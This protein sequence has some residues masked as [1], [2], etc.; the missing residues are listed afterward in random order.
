MSSNGFHSSPSHIHNLRSLF[1]VF[2][3]DLAIDLGT[4][5]TLVYARGKGIV[6]NEPSIVAMNKV[7]GEV[8][9]VGREAKEMLGRTPGNIVAIRPMKD[10]VIADFE[11]TEAML[12]YF[13]QKAHH[14]RT[15]VRPRVIVCVPS[16]ITEV[17]KRA[18]RDSALAASA[19]EVYLVGEPMAAA[20]GGG[21]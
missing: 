15:L 10:G 4:A 18:V 20:I 11:V 13:I 14:R 2:S 19:R 16:G 21:P 9:A 3:S 12:R 1:S 6:V 5:N 7:T 8:E 17:E